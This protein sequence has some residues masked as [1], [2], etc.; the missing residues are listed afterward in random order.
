MNFSRVNVIVAMTCYGLFAAVNFVEGMQPAFETSAH[1]DTNGVSVVVEKDRAVFTVESPSGIGRTVI[2]KPG[3]NWPGAV[4]LRLR[5]NGLESF[6]VSIDNVTL[7]AS[8]SSQ[9]GQ[10]RVW[11]EGQE[12]SPLHEK[13]PYW[14]PVKLLDTFG[15]PTTKIPFKTASSKFCCQKSAS[16]TLPTP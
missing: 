3:E 15:K 4:V 10:V 6:R 8:V 14:M 5:L 11:K 12:V 2:K 16:K 7:E 9:T 1:R 13:S